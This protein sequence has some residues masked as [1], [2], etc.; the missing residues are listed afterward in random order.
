MNEWLSKAFFNSSLFSNR[1]RIEHF[2]ND[3]TAFSVDFYGFEL[4]PLLIDLGLA[5]VLI[6][7]G[8]V[9]SR[10]KI[11]VQKSPSARLQI[12]L[13]NAGISF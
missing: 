7:F 4:Q 12:S 2:D 3:R 11:D 8:V 5:S 1:V 6:H 10:E 13:E 9:Y